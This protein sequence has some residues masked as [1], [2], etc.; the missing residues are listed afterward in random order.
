[1]KSGA[2]TGLVSC[3]N[4]IFRE[5][6]LRAS[7]R[8]HSENARPRINGRSRA[9]IF[10]SF[11]ILQLCVSIL[12]RWPVF[13]ELA[14]GFD[15]ALF[16]KNVDHSSPRPQCLGYVGQ[17]TKL[18]PINKNGQ[19]LNLTTHQSLGWVVRVIKK[20]NCCSIIQPWWLGGRAVV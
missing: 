14:A 8:V 1:M 2:S 20:I 4:L 5:C 13:F 9:C 15:L 19:T 18:T 17:V 7:D 6:F 12:L 10:V 11:P 16:R 3:C